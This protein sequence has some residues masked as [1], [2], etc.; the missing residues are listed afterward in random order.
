MT[1]RVKVRFP[2]TDAFKASRSM[3]TEDVTERV[4][5][6]Q[7]GYSSFELP[8]RAEEAFRSEGAAAAARHV[9]AMERLRREFGAEVVEDYR[10]QMEADAFDFTRQVDVAE[11]A[12]SLDDV[13]RMIGA[14]DAWQQ[15]QGDGIAIAIVDTG[16]DGSRAEFPQSRRVG[17]WQPPGEQPWTD[18]EGHG[19]MCAAIA[20]ASADAGGRYQGVAPG[21]GLIACKTWFYDSELAAIYDFLTDRANRG[22]KI[23]ASNSF[24]LNTGEPPASDPNSD[25]VPAL[26]DAINAGIIVAF[27]AGNNHQTAGGDPAACNPNSIWLH[28]SRSD[29][30][31][32]ATCDLDA[33]MWFYSSRGPGQFVDEPWAS[34]K[35]DVTAPTPRNGG[36]A[37]GADDRVLPD[38][39][40]TSGACPQVAGLAA[41]LTSIDGTLDRNTLHTMIRDTARPLGHGRDCEGQG[42]IDCA[43]AVRRLRGAGTV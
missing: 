22:E 3:E 31:V 18:W 29:L 40:G 13:T 17:A 6:E 34:P 21:A 7:R 36:I 2:S 23:I 26:E 35:P 27:S 20:A 41:L 9:G 11:Q 30:L 42:L 32:V 37:Y 38:G 43:A 33:R 1:I 19:T 14:P 25:F 8:D 39:W 15:T 24:G 10:Y 12:A 28:K 4:A 5:N 16:I